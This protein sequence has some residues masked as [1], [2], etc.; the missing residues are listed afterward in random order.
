MFYDNYLEFLIS[1]RIDYIISYGLW[2]TYVRAFNDH[3]PSHIP[4]PCMHNVCILIILIHGG[5][6]DMNAYS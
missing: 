4:C 5:R 3:Y 2:N 6:V 1:M